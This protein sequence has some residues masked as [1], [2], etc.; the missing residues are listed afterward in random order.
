MRQQLAE[1]CH[2]DEQDSLSKFFRDEG[3]LDCAQLFRQTVGE[4][5]YREFLEQ[6][7]DVR[8]HE[9]VE[10]TPSHEALVALGDR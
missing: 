1:R 2:A 3:P 8:R 10:A 5:N 7:F 9:F 6:Q 4:A